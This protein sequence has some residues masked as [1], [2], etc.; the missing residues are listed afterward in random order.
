MPRKAWPTFPPS[1]PW[2]PEEDEKIAEITQIGLASHCWPT[3]LPGRRHS[4][5]VARRLDLQDAGLCGKTP[6]I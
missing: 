1:E 4:E 3:A 5:I 2:T 6:S